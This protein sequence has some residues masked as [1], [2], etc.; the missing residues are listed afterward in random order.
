[1]KVRRDL[2]LLVQGVGR[3]YGVATAVFQLS[4]DDKTHQQSGAIMRKHLFASLAIAA[5]AGSIVAQGAV[6]APASETIAPSAAEIQRIEQRQS[7]LLAAHLAGMKAGLNLN[8][9][10]AKYWPAFESAIQDAE[11]ARS[12]RWLQA[13][14]RMERGRAPLSDRPDVDDGGPYR[15]DGSGTAQGRR[16]GQTAV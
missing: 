10:Q 8:D 16:G 2:S 14:E 4:I 11:K 9:E 5:L 7:V 1:V 6:A 12:D 15:E 13:R 3:S